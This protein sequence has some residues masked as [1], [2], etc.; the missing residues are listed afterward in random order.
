MIYSW[1]W[2]EWPILLSAEV[3]VDLKG[4]P[5]MLWWITDLLNTSEMSKH[6][7]PLNPHSHQPS[8]SSCS[9]SAKSSSPNLLPCQSKMTCLLKRGSEFVFQI[10]HE[11]VNHVGDWHTALRSH[12]PL[13]S[14]LLQQPWLSCWGRCWWRIMYCLFRLQARTYFTV[15]KVMRRV[16]FYVASGR[17]YELLKLLIPS[18]SSLRAEVGLVSTHP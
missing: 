4:Q 16:G 8:R 1:S 10:T 2:G 7:V 14:C 13:S 17:K 12:G 3:I 6:I 5:T 18:L 11:P 9:L 15:F